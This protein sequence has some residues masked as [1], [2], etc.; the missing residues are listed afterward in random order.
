MNFVA[1]CMPFFRLVS[2]G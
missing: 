1:P 2:Q